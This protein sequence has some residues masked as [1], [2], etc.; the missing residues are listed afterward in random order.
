MSFPQKRESRNWIPDSIRDDSM[1]IGILS[2]YQY[3][4]DM[5]MKEKINQQLRI[6]LQKLGVSPSDA[7]IKKMQIEYPEPK[8]G[9][10]SSN[11]ALILSKNI[12]QPSQELA[13]RIIE[14]ID[15]TDF[16]KVETAGPG[17][18]NFTL[19][20]EILLSNMT[21]Q[22]EEHVKKEKI[23]L[24]YFQPNIAKPLHIGHLRTAIIG[25]ALKRMLIYAG[26]EVESDTHMGDWGTQFG[27]LIHAYKKYGD[28][29][30][31]SKDPINELNKLYIR[32][33][34]EAGQDK[35][36]HEAAKQEFVKLEKGD[37]ENRKIWKQ[38]VDWSVAK[39]MR[40]NDLLDI[41]P[42]D[43]HWPESFYEDKMSAIVSRLKRKGLI[44][45]SQG[46][47]IVDL[48]KQGMG[49]AIIIKSDGGTTYLL[50]DLA[51]F[52]FV[53]GLG[54]NKHLYVVDNRQ[55][56]HYRQ[57][58]AIL[59][60][61]GEMED[62]EGT[63]INYGIMTFKGEAFSTRKGNILTP[64][65]VLLEAENRVTK[66]IKE[67][68]PNLKG[69]EEVMDAVAKA[70]LKFFDLS[71]NRHSDIEFDWEQALDFEGKS[72][73]YIQYTYA[74]LA[75][76]LRKPGVIL[77]EAKDRP[78]AGGEGAPQI[79]SSLT[80]QNDIS[81]TERRIMFYL[82]IFNEKVND[83]LQDY[84]PNIF[85]DYLFE[86]ANLINRFYHE[87]PVLTEADAAKKSFRLGL[88]STSKAALK[89][90]M[91]LLGI[92]TLEEM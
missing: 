92:A 80:A 12:K 35:S 72:G 9:D 81:E 56:L 6:A 58:F 15:K 44:V 78:P 36:V 20:Q 26:L 31:I 7:E 32:V 41:L 70:A 19:K 84:L 43:H 13:A 87:S 71:H 17:F 75:S 39:F 82:S 42:F 89:Q 10:Y 16:E 69:K 24:E 52:V 62:N 5:L 27:Y 91:E 21:P 49:V 51:A 61:M 33:N 54:F 18:I 25:D 50:R 59:K 28:I 38:F 37:E 79:D 8:L 90:G 74:R 46:A 1:P 4:Y 53:R 86:L 88:V 60:M 2:V 22:A 3:N 14:A 55:S 76:I 66:V 34:E 63:H 67:K 77:N 11:A 40:I 83:S 57:L 73:P 68:N 29:E 48:E 65:E 23:L 64:E 47:W 45:E 85:A 30:I